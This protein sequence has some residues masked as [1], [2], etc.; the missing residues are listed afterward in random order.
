MAGIVGN[1]GVATRPVSIL[2]GSQG[3]CLRT[4]PPQAWSDL[5]LRDVEVHPIVVRV[6][7][8]YVRMVVY[9]RF[10]SSTEPSGLPLTI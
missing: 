5:S 3:R 10:R 9:R 1:E 6:R 8:S 2:R 7:P 4:R